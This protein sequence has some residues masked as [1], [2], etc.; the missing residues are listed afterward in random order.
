MLLI[1]FFGKKRD[2]LFHKMFGSESTLCH[3]TKLKLNLF[4][5]LRESGLP[6][7]VYNVIQGLGQTG[8]YLSDHQ[9]VS[10]LSFTGSTPTGTK[11]MQAG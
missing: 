10:K 5:I 7:G 6:S 2:D 1:A 4:Q 3:V 9:E 11:I 8:S